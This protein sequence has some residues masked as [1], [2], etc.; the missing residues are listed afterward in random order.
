MRQSFHIAINSCPNF[1][2]RRVVQTILSASDQFVPLAD[3]PDEIW[4]KLPKQRGGRIGGRDTSG[5]PSRSN[6]PEHPTHYADIDVDYAPHGKN[7]REL[8]RLDPEKYL[9][10]QAWLSYYDKLQS[11]AKAT[12]DAAAAAQYGDKLKRGLLPFRLWQFFDAMVGFAREGDILRFV[13]AAG[14]AA[15]YMG[16]A[17]Q[18]L[19]G[20]VLA[21]GDKSRAGPRTDPTTG[22]SLPY[23]AGVHSAFETNMVSRHAPD[24]LHR[25]KLDLSQQTAHLPLCRSGAQVARATIELMHQAAQTLPPAHILDVFEE[26]GGTARVAVLDAMYEALAVPTAQ[27]MASGARYLA[28]LWDSAWTAGNCSKISDDQLLEQDTGKVQTTYADSEFISSLT[29]DGIESVLVPPS[30][31]SKRQWP[32]K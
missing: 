9:T 29:L 5:G 25:V 13:T 30:D 6:G 26:A 12:H 24:L 8:C 10:V 27:V 17:S 2:S 4:K 16:D 15:H 32:P 21:D 3:V 1:A 28:L 31:G 11:L 18:P 20:S 23:G 14:L 19:H 22:V 7:L